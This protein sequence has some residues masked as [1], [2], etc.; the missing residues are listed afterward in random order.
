MFALMFGMGL[1]LTTGDFRRIARAP[2]ATVLGTVLQ[3]I[4]MPA[5]GIALARLYDLPPALAA[6]LVV[7]AACPG[8]M[9]SNLFIYFARAS[10]AL[11]ITLTATATMAALFTLPLWVQQTLAGTDGA[12]VVP[13]GAT[14]LQLAGLTVLPVTLGMA[15]R[16]QW[17]GAQ[18]LERWLSRIGA[19]V[20][21]VI[22]SYDSALQPEMPVTEFQQSLAPAAWLAVAA[23]GLGVGIPALFR[24]RSSDVVTIGVELVVKNL[25][26]GVVLVRES[27]AF[28]ALVPVFAFSLFQM[29]MG[30]GLL[31]AWRLLALTGLVAGP[32]PR[33]PSAPA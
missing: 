20:I 3:L 29:P 1:T 33:A 16:S 13:V 9:F 27:L 6:G 30:I 24:L 12:I 32:E 2:V 23:V 10:S 14:A 11:S 28:E 25:L 19:L 4:V 7:C 8:G 15:V 26:L 18:T 22:L 5:V 17:P 31:V 21:V